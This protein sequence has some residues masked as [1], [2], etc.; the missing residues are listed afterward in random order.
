M[1]AKGHSK[2][3]FFLL[4]IGVCGCG[5]LLRVSKFDPNNP[6]GIP[7]YVKHGICVQQT[8]Y[9]NPYWRLTM[10]YS[11]SDAQP[12]TETVLISDS[13][14]G[15]KELAVLLA[16]LAQKPAPDSQTVMTAW[17][18][19]KDVNRSFNPWNDLSG[20]RLLSNSSSLT[21]EVNYETAYAINQKKPFSG[22]SQAD[23]KLASDGTLSEA[24]GQT[25]DN[26]FA[27]VVSALP[28]SSLI[29]SAA[30]IVAPVGK[31]ETKPT[32]PA[33]FTLKQ[34]QRYVKTVCSKSTLES[35][36]ICEVGVPLKQE[37]EKVAFVVSDVGS[38]DTTDAGAQD[39]NTDSISISGTIKLPKS[40]Q[41]TA[42]AQNSA[43]D[44]KTPSNPPPSTKG[45]PTGAT[46]K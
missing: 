34:E 10:T 6:Q 39:K 13:A 21:T 24:S 37:S 5:N 23:F 14:H 9:A 40:T 44:S 32:V 42:S 15:Q 16:S 35:G 28:I 22:S 38:T 31:S 3:L 45:K 29:T 18:A 4:C 11:P 25:Q 19:L 46:S 2:G 43:V 17:Q 30:G 12:L 36:E 33:Q 27:T 7:F 41:P 8:T 20:Q 26:T 1:P